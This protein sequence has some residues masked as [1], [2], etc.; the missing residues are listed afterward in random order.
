MFRAARTPVSASTTA[1][2]SRRRSVDASTTPAGVVGVVEMFLRCNILAL[3]GGGRSPRYSPNKVM[4]WD[5]H[6]SRMHRRAQ[7]P[8]RGPRAGAPAPRQ[9]RRRPRAQDLRL[10]LQDLK[11]STR[12]T[13]PPTPRVSCALSLTQGNTVMAFPGLNKGQVRVELYDAGVTKFI[14]AHH[15]DPRAG[16]QPRRR[17]ARHLVREGH[18]RPRLRPGEGHVAARVQDAAR[19]GPP[20]I[21]SP[22]TGEGLACTSDK[23]TVHVYATSSRAGGDCVRRRTGAADGS[24]AAAGARARVDVFREEEDTP[25]KAAAASAISFVK[26]FL[27]KYFS[28]EREPG[29]VQAPGVHQ[30]VGGVRSRVEHAGG[31]DGGGDVLQDRVRSKRGGLASSWSSRGYED[32]GGR[33]RGRGRRGQPRTEP[34]GDENRDAAQRREVGGAN[35]GTIERDDVERRSPSRSILFF[36]TTNAAEDTRGGSRGGFFFSRRRSR[37]LG[38]LLDFLFERIGRLTTRRG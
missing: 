24:R 16:A 30:V 32:G 1:T 33:G 14:S 38:F 13:P 37:V 7:L 29:A 34:R 21:P 2:C 19:T 20:Y 28:S 15:G 36:P 11:P 9:D 31:G 25:G 5:D 8:R 6:Q 18:P 22:L 10:Q 27:P 4:I 35:D 12:R 3:V 17:T 26:G 23:G